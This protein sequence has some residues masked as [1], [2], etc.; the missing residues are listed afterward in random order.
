MIY[1]FLINNFSMKPILIFSL[2]FFSCCLMECKQKIQNEYMEVDPPIQSYINELKYL[3]RIE[4]L[5]QYRDQ[6]EVGQISSYDTTGGNNDG[7]SGLYSYVRKEGH[8]RIVAELQ[9]PGI[10]ERIWTPTPSEDTLQFYFDGET[11]PRINMRFIDLFKGDQF[12]FLSPIVGNEIGGYYSYLPIPYQ[13]SCKIV[14]IGEK[15]YFHQIQYRKF[16]P[17]SNLK[18]YPS[19]WNKKEKEA[20]QN[21]LRLWSEKRPWLESYLDS[22]YRN[23]QEKSISFTILP[24][25]TRTLLDLNQAG[26]IIKLE[27]EPSN[28]FAGTFK[29]LLIKIHWDDDP[30]P[31]VYCPVADF[32]GY[33]FGKPSAR[34]ILLGSDQG[35]NYCYIPMPFD[36]QAKIELIYKE[37]KEVDQPPLKIHSNIEFTHFKRNPE[38]EGKFYTQWRRVIH[39]AE[40]NPYVIQETKGKG[41]HIGTILQARGLKAGMTLFFEGDD[42]TVIDR[43]I[44]LHGTGSEDYFN[45]GWYALP[46]RWDRAFSLPIHGCLEYS[47]PMART[48]GYRFYLTDKISYRDHI[49]HTIEHGPT[50]NSYPVDYTS[51]AFYYSD[52][53]PASIMEPEASLRQVYRPDTLILTPDLLKVTVGLFNAASRIDWGKFLFHGEDQSI[54]VIHLDEIPRGNYHLYLSYQKNQNGCN[55]SI[56]QRQKR[57][58]PVISSFNDNDLQVEHEYVGDIQ[59]NNEYTSVSLMKESAG[60]ENQLIFNSLMLVKKR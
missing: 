23:I 43:K 42:S 10:I 12:P 27:L 20:L 19:E 4:L 35:I 48:G 18:S 36:N 24:G 2:Y 13:Q 5:P 22:I 53:A 49:L 11:E 33:A 6:T 7:F 15:L 60:T 1:E 8:K 56:W 45:G 55:F 25:E 47:I 46:N 14:Y 29:D 59:L 44:M 16:A 26:R 9:G 28:A 39:P 21:A 41:H 38:Y 58:S 57:I 3:Y 31:A 50:G 34:S 54:L 52:Q 40:G 51:V 37:R 17:S 32:F 30:E